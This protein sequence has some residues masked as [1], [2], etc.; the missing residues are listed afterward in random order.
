MWTFRVEVVLGGKGVDA[1]LR[2]LQVLKDA[3]RTVER[4]AVTNRARNRRGVVQFPWEF[5]EGSVC[6][7]FLDTLT[8]V[9][10]LYVRLRERRQWGSDFPECGVDWSPQLFD[11]FLVERQLDLSSVTARLRGCS[12]VVLSGRHRA[13]RMA[14]WARQN[15]TGSCRGCDRA[16]KSGTENATAHLSPSWSRQGGCRNQAPESDMSRRRLL[17]VCA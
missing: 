5:A 12:C 11:F 17:V 1:N 10:E 2:I 4:V 9:F 8:P 6:V 7:V 3:W 16:C 14:T 13:V 15:A